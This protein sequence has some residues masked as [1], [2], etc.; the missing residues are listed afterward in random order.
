MKA[1]IALISGL[2]SVLLWYLKTRETP[3]AKLKRI[4]EIFDEDMERVNKA[5]AEGDYI[6][7]AGEYARLRYRILRA[8][9]PLHA[10][11]RD[12]ADKRR[13]V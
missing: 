8:T 5:I 7:I 2:V 10:R 11:G 1:V 13:V 6:D 9:D 4:G 12:Q 3:E